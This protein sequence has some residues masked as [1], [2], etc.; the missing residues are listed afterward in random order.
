[1]YNLDQIKTIIKKYDENELVKI[2]KYIRCLSDDNK[3]ELYDWLLVLQDN[4]CI[5][6]LL[7]EF[8]YFGFGMESDNE[9]ALVWFQKSAKRSCTSSMNSIGHIHRTNDN[10]S[11]AM[12]WF[13]KASELGN[14]DALYNIG[15]LYQNG[16]GV[17]KDYVIAKEWFLKGAEKNNYRSLY[18][19]GN[20]YLK[21]LGITKDITTAMAY[22]IKSAILG[23]S[24]AMNQI[25]LLYHNGE[26]VEKNYELAKEWY[27]KAINCDDINALC[28]L[29]GLYRSQNS[30]YQA[31]KYY[32]EAYDKTDN[33]NLRTSCKNTIADILQYHGLDI[34]RYFNKQEKKI[35]DL[36]KQIEVLKHS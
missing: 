4:K 18:A 32:I 15:L 5:M 25:G 27:L 30:P 12:E 14:T 24:V 34:L 2:H 8:H 9:A 31:I 23:Y 29:G 10:Y 20:L 35:E 16:H 6:K 17:T 28:N 13:K 19:I 1:M 21:G 26:I 36:N 7:G 3:K 33:A 11:M 22:F